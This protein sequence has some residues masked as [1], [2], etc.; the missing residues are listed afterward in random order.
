L[1]QCFI[2]WALGARAGHEIPAD[3]HDEIIIHSEPV[4][5]GSATWR[6]RARWTDSETYS[7]RLYHPF[8]DTTPQ[9]LTV[10]LA[11]SPGPFP[12]MVRRRGLS[13]FVPRTENAPGNLRTSSHTGPASSGATCRAGDSSSVG[14]RA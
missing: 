12:I 9:G 7:T 6:V 3:P 10:A 4:S 1:Q 14:T 13:L 5:V 8:H 11:R 2:S